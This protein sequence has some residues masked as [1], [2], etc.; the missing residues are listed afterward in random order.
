MRC[1]FYLK[2]YETVNV[3]HRHI[4]VGIDPGTTVGVAIMDLNGRLLDVF[5][6]KNCSF[7]DIINRIISYGKP[8]VV[9]TDVS[10]T[11]S[12]VRKMGSIFAS[13]VNELKASMTVE[14]KEKLTAKY[15][16]RCKNTH[17]RDAL[18]A[19]IDA[20]NKYKKKFAQVGKKTPPE[21]EEEVK[22]MVIRGISIQKAINM[23]LNNSEKA[24]SHDKQRAE[25]ADKSVN[26]KD[27]IER[28]RAE[29]RQ[30]DEEIERLKEFQER[31]KCELDC[32]K[33]EVAELHEKLRSR[34]FEMRREVMRERI[35]KELRAEISR[36][37]SQL[38]SVREE[39]ARL[40][41]FIKEL[42][43]EMVHE[44]FMRVKV[45]RNF[46]RKGIEEVERKF[47]LERGDVLF[48]E[49]G[50][51]AGPKTAEMLAEKGVSAIIYGRE[52]SPIAY[53]KLA[54]RGIF[55][56]HESE[57]PVKHRRGSDFAAVDEKALRCRM[58]E[59][60]RRRTKKHVLFSI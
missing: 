49:D 29:I 9:A 57:I 58:E 60:L 36:L 33:R 7:S 5:S 1:Q 48:I 41:D 6:A 27:Y 45:L 18:A 4:I 23:L 32:K 46:S 20:F 3:R 54:E 12:A 47:G 8:V 50:S 42:K 51:G 56:F 22:A 38:K 24:D 11:P 43:G 15:G 10:P 19:C 2:D 55:T 16:Y 14:Y 59:E 44:G 35:V 31:L 53:E 40:K 52:L 26:G 25:S 28:L 30:K 34:I 21:I 17:E 37:K 39:N 13:V